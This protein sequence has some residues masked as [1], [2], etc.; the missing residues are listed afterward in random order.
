VA[1]RLQ[2]IK[3]AKK[4]FWKKW[5]QQVFKGRMLSHTRTKEEHIVA[6]GSMVLLAEA[7][8]DDHTYKMCILESVKPGEDGYVRTVSIRYTNPG[9]ASG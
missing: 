9:K 5:M 6:L 3:D 8:N 1:W 2:F 7:E 4:Q